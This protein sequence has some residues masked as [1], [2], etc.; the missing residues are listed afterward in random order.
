M[1]SIFFVDFTASSGRITAMSYYS[2]L[3]NGTYVKQVKAA[4]YWEVG[5]FDREID[6]AISQAV[7]EGNY[8]VVPELKA[9]RRPMKVAIDEGAKGIRDGLDN[10]SLIAMLVDEV[11]K[12]KAIYGGF[13]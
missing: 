9:L 13:Y 1:S 10:D 11:A 5:R 4:A 3:S 7:A 6:S 12:A 8:K 2:L